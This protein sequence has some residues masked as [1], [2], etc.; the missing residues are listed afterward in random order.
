MAMSH[1]TDQLV[2]QHQVMMTLA[3]V[4]P[5]DIP[6]TLVVHLA[7]PDLLGEALC[8]L[9]SD[10]QL[11]AD[12]R[13][14]GA[15]PA[16]SINPR[17]Q[18]QLRED[19]S[20]GRDPAEGLIEAHRGRVSAALGLHGALRAA[21][22]Q[23]QLVSQL[24]DPLGAWL[25]HTSVE[26]DLPE[27]LDAFNKITLFLLEHNHDA[28]ALPFARRAVAG[29]QRH[30]GARHPTTLT[31]LANLAAVYSNGPQQRLGIRLLEKVIADREDL[32]G[33][34]DPSV[35]AAR[36]NLG[37]MY[38]DSERYEDATALVQDI[39]RHQTQANGPFHRDT[40][41]SKKNLATIHDRAGRRAEAIAMWVPLLATLEQ[42]LGPHDVL[43]SQVRRNLAQA[44]SLTE[45][46]NPSNDIDS[47]SVSAHGYADRAQAG[48]PAGVSAHVQLA[49]AMVDQA[50]SLESVAILRFAI[51]AGTRTLGTRDPYVIWARN[52]LGMVHLYREEP[53]TA[54]DLAESVLHDADSALGRTHNLTIQTVQLLWLIYTSLDR[55]QA[56]E[57]L[58]NERQQD[59][60]AELGYSD[61][62]VRDLAARSALRDLG[63]SDPPE[64]S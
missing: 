9:I 15:A 18:Q 36:I 44:R 5:H 62:L 37:A 54:L 16:V 23:A 2:L 21:E 20:G 34:N 53:D 40:L 59:L 31:Y 12:P 52:R 22:G 10:G 51:D 32:L 47:L 43:T 28:E 19:P 64:S 41:Q 6:V 38:L 30:L 17:L 58:M 13:A 11:T 57:R 60:T 48:T 50:R 7:T 56:A 55:P 39:H 61:P 33:P 14:V 1:K 45:N 46:A 63:V 3:W 35:W 26:D 27:S 49:L 25:L 29:A 4:C 42:H 24:V 8:S